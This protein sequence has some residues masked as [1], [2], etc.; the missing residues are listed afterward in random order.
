MFQV[1][2]DEVQSLDSDAKHGVIQTESSRCAA[3][4][5]KSRVTSQPDG[6]DVTMTPSDSKQDRLS[7]ASSS[8]GKNKLL[9]S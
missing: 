8:L 5:M 4:R 7:S 9:L 2:S 1:I 6:D 3:E